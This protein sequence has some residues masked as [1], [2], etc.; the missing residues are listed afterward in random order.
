MPGAED[1]YIAF[2]FLSPRFTYLAIPWAFARGL[3]VNE[4][5]LD[6]GADEGDREV[7]PKRVRLP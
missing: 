5:H 3:V 2:F 7:V 1:T 6:L 4:G